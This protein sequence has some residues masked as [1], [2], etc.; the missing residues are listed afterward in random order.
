[1]QALTE[2]QKR[3][4]G[5]AQPC[6]L[7][8]NLEGR[9]AGDA[10]PPKGFTARQ[11]RLWGELFTLLDESNVLTHLDIPALNA[12]VLAYEHILHSEP[13]LTEIKIFLQLLGKFGLLPSDRGKVMPVKKREISKLDQL[14]AKRAAS[15]G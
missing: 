7:V 8:V 10:Q 13:R 5:T 12:L 6:R 2:E 3:I 4:K 1:M 11:K 14:R 15:V 9:P